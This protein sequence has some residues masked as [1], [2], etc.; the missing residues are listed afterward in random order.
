M[1]EHG[2]QFIISS[3]DTIEALK[4]R[5][6]QTFPLRDEGEIPRRRHFFDTVDWRL[7]RK[8]LT[9][10]EERSE[11][12]RRLVMRDLGT[13]AVQR[14]VDQL[15]MPRFATE[16]PRGPFRE[17]LAAIVAARALLPAA[18]LRTVSHHLQLRDRERKIVA[19]IEIEIAAAGYARV[20]RMSKRLH[21]IAV[22]G[23]PEPADRLARFAREQ[24][25]LEPATNSLL[26]D[27]LAV[28]GRRALDYSARPSIDL[29]ADEPAHEAVRRILLQLADIIESNIPGAREHLDPEF[30][31]DLRVAVRR[32]RTLLSRMRS[33]FDKEQL[34]PYRGEFAWLGSV[35]GPCRDLDVYLLAFD[36][37]AASLPPEQRPALEPFRDYLQRCH[38][39]EQRSLSGWLDSTRLR[40]L[41][42]NW[43]HFL[44]HPGPLYEGAP[45]ATRPLKRVTDD[46][47]W[48]AYRRVRDRGRRIRA[49]APARKLH[50]LRIET[51]KLRYLLELF[52]PL[53]PRKKLSSFIAVL[54]QLQN[55]LGDFH[56]FDIQAEALRRFAIEMEHRHLGSAET[57]Q[58]IEKLAQGLDE[59][60]RQARKEFAAVFAEFDRKRHQKLARTLFRPG[61][62]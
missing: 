29:E 21:V 2:F 33:V 35:T 24:L 50:A 14:W 3:H 13:G 31:H 22:R 62:K 55:N 60:Q 53:Y 10:E 42:S 61:R 47:I 51:K 40:A 25:H 43:R 46:R 28:S 20:H 6:M 9:L 56:D 39:E 16:L 8:G 45:A 19:R 15:E 34:R 48:H 37:Y 30:L 17:R 23:H 41:L 52:R 49:K 38:V 18:E 58:A 5:L 26:D 1:A 27:A 36:G 44:V 54:R 12:T 7:Y 11:Q 4:G 57:L 59:R 32:T